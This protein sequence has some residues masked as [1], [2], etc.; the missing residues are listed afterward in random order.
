MISVQRQ[1]FF[2]SFHYT[3]A[4]YLGVSKHWTDCI[5]YCYLLCNCMCTLRVLFACSEVNYCGV[6]R[7]SQVV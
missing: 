3:D 7:A 4:G 1:P 2:N 5:M 6:T